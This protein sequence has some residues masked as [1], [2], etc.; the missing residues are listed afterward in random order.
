M[1]AKISGTDLSKLQ[2]R[3]LKLS[4][5]RDTGGWTDLISSVYCGSVSY[6]RTLEL[7]T[8]LLVSQA[9]NIF[10]CPK[11]D[12]SCATALPEQFITASSG[13]ASWSPACI[14]PS[15][16]VSTGQALFTL[17][18]CPMLFPWKSSLKELT[19]QFGFLL[20]DFSNCLW[21]AFDILGKRTCASPHLTQ[22]LFSLNAF[23]TIQCLLYVC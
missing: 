12:F 2:Q 11:N 6:P 23:L 1:E 20:R 19:A 3:N 22:M 16:R 10:V 5:W 7:E 21:G 17:D 18:A 4:A 13:T 8:W 14:P 15:I 9:Y